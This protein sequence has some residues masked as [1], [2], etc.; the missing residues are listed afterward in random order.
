MSKIRDITIEGYRSI[1]SIKNLELRPLNVLI[2]ANGAGKSNFLSAFELL[3]TAISLSETPH[4]YAQRAGG[5]SRLLHFGPKV[6]QQVKFTVNFSDSS[7]GFGVE[8]CVAP[9]DTFTW[10]QQVDE[11]K[12]PP[13]FE[14]T[15][16]PEHYGNEHAYLASVVD[17]W[18]IF[19]FHD[20]GALSPI[21]QTADL[22]D[23]RA[24]RADGSNLTAYLNLLA[25]KHTQSYDF[26][27][28]TIKQANPF[29]EDFI[30]K[31][32][33]LN[34]QKI[35]LEWRQKGSEAY[36][37]VHSFS[38]GTLRFIA[39]TTLLLQPESF[40]PSLILLD[41]PEL[42]LH[43]YA[44]HLL[45][46]MLE[47]ASVDSQIIVAT[48]SPILLDYFKPEDVLVA[49]R[50]DG[51]TEFHRQDSERLAAWLEEYSLGELWEKNELGGRPAPESFEE[52]HG[53]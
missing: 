53:E 40:R 13:K 26:I 45:A 18:R 21:K 4:M 50:V 48:Q 39:L 30:L 8:L 9:Y 25:K 49:E 52:P 23:N 32:Q 35:Q 33:R 7:G 14:S 38:D 20:T 2:G 31:P 28:S 29:I 6:T 22:H 11:I 24:L 17:D 3:R 1:K 51:A 46:A 12:P 34:E 16:D 41:E 19:H 44:I 36:F 37:D 47:H 5:A 42:G 27:L 15:I 43:P 10:L